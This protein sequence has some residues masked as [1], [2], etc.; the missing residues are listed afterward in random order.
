MV[1]GYMGK[2]LF[3]DLSTGVIKAEEPDEKSNHDYIGGYGIGARVLYN[4]QKAGVDPMGPENTLGFMT[5]PLTGTPAT[6]GSRYTV[7][8]K[9]P[10]TNGW[11]DASCGGDFG[12]NLKFSGYDGLFFTGISEK[13][14][15]LFIDN[16]KAELR[17]ASHVWG[18]STF[19]TDEIMQ[20]EHG[21]SV[22]VASIG[23]AGERRALIANI[24]N[25]GGDAAGRS[26]MGALMGSKKVKAV[27]VKGEMKVPVAD[28]ERAMK[29]RKEH[30]ADINKEFLE[31]FHTYGT[32]THAEDS[33]HSGDSPVKNWGGVGVVEM[34]DA[35]G[36]NKEYINSKVKSR[37]GCWRCPAACKGILEEGTGVYRYPG[38]AH[39]P[40]YET[41]AAFGCNCLV[42][43][44]GAIVMANHLCNSYGM[45]TISTGSVI[46]FAMECYEHG[47]ITRADTDGI[48]LIWGNHQAMIALLKKI[49]KREGIGD[50]LADGVMRAA[51]KLGKPAGK[52]A[53]HIGGQEL[54][55]HDPKL[56]F[57]AFAGKLVAA[58]YQIDAT[59]GRHTA[60]FSWDQFLVYVI[61]AAGLCLMSQLVVTDPNRYLAEFLS[62]VTGWERS[63]EE[64]LVEDR[65]IA[66]I[67]HVF[68]L[69]EG[70]NPLKRKVHPR[71]I[72]RPPLKEGPL[73][74]KRA[75][76]DA[77]IYWSLGKLDWDRLTT[78]P[79]RKILLEL[80]MYDVARDFYS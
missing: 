12:P 1:S 50:I 80:G 32:T 55:M 23:Q 59:P 70:I 41:L 2:L 15:Y 75:D 66:T 24:M 37:A 36:I 5:G 26:G 10:L 72:G 43:D 13:P 16:G 76:I 29:L 68:N 34:P 53:V 11:G 38:G 35:S 27:V 45:D 18:K 22:K 56:D 30:I 42:N 17:D 6:F 14:A 25:K 62:A 33:V 47:V 52:Y 49:V 20:D 7:V 40:E 39:R 28:M 21:K 69:R 71:I 61:N 73:A 64:L 48:E 77:Q 44:V 79:S 58:A 74:G 78:L 60:A 51:E 65:R 63:E 31:D 4:R 8:G 67:R 3:V 54:G 46:A 57:P 9:S 19:E